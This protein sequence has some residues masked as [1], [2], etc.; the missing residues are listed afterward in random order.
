MCFRRGFA[1]LIPQLFLDACNTNMLKLLAKRQTTYVF[2]E[3][4]TSKFQT[5][6]LL[7][8]TLKTM[9][10]SGKLQEFNAFKILETRCTIPVPVMENVQILLVSVERF[11]GSSGAI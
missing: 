3:R 4:V 7:H 11:V 8:T 9:L 5:F 2:H 6:T 1:Y 10:G